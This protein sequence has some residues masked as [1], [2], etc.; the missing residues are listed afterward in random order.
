MTRAYWRFVE[1]AGRMLDLCDRDAV[2]GDL[3]ETGEGGWRSSLDV[4][5]LVI[6]RQRMHWRSWRP[7]LAVFGLAL[8]G[9]LILMG[10]SVSISSS[11]ERLVDHE[12][13]IRPHETIQEALLQLLCR[14]LLLIGGAWLG[15]FVMGSMSRKTLW[16]SIVSSGI[17]CL[18]CLL[19]FRETSLSRLCLFVFL[20]PAALGVRQ[21]LRST[22][23][24]LAFAIFLA[25]AI[26]TLTI[27]PTNSR[28][29][30]ALNWSLVWPAWYV[31][32]TAR[33]HGKTA[34][35]N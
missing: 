20:V 10:F 26:T 21:A 28:G 19:R 16:M 13:L 25:V 29:V 30:W 4:V 27:L 3:L 2:L 5:G 8:P 24:N 1:L 6:R 22:R 33:R 15:G 31:L 14:S 34:A 17:P 9:S 12:I 11:L 32:A 35:Q 23:I 7:W 18:F